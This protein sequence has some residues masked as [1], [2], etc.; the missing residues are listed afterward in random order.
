VAKILATANPLGNG[1]VSG[2][3]GDPRSR[4]VTRFVLVIQ[5]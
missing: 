1:E 5:K 3:G 4:L 2:F